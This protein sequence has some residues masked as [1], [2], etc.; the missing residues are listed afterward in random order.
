MQNWNWYLNGLKTKLQL[1]W[2]RHAILISAKIIKKQ[3][4]CLYISRSIFFHLYSLVNYKCTE[5][6]CTWS[7]CAHLNFPAIGD[8]FPDLSLYI[9]HLLIVIH[10]NLLRKKTQITILIRDLCIRCFDY[11]LTEKLIY[12]TA[13]LLYLRV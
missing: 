8:P 2:T 1:C 13:F 6:D 4:V 9:F 10:H 3:K 11:P 7:C 12:R 5:L